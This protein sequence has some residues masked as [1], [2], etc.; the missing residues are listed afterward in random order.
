MN[1]LI[2]T[3]WTRYRADGDPGSRHDLLDQYIGL[4]HHAAREMA[5]RIPPEL[6]LDDL[7]SAGTIGLV[8]ALETFEPS[9]GLAFSTFAMPRIR[10]AM[11]DELRS[12]DWVPRSVRDRNRKVAK[13]RAILEQRL[14]RSAT[15]VEIA[16]T[17]EVDMETCRRWI[18]EADGPFLLVLDPSARPAD[19]RESPR[20]SET[21]AD[22]QANEPGDGLV[23]E[24][25]LEELRA[26]VEELPSKERLILSLYYYEK[27]N[28]RQIGEVLHITES[29]V[30][31]IH[32]RVIARLRSHILHV[33]RPAKRSPERRGSAVDP[34]SR[35]I[36]PGKAPRAA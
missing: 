20:L 24:E 7:I 8:Q 28:L 32:S 31:Q 16:E 26:A 36:A 5:R 17:L 35:G 10:G 9:R 3:L 6:D 29:R 22:P 33:E 34:P 11:L 1:G 27:L 23:R 18:A 19:G 2:D 15:D 4:V 21:L 25:T 13:A 14:G 30:S 12:W